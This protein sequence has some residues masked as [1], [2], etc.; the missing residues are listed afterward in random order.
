MT[1]LP[2]LAVMLSRSRP[3]P[4]ALPCWLTFTD[5]TSKVGWAIR[6]EAK[7]TDGIIS[8]FR[9]KDRE[10]PKICG[11]GLRAARQNR[12]WRGTLYSYVQAT[13][14]APDPVHCL[15][16]LCPDRSEN[17]DAQ[18]ISGLQHRRRL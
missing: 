15:P 13:L 11:P 12:L 16:V 7:K 3:S 17:H 18:G 14:S 8:S 2:G 4:P 6:M 1:R 5:A 9:R 10:V